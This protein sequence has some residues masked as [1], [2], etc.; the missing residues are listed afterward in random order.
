MVFRR[1]SQLHNGDKKEEEEKVVLY[2]HTCTFQQVYFYIPRLT[3]INPYTHSH[4]S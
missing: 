2:T 4:V 3:H 1:I